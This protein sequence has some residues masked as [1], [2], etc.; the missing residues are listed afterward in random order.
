[1]VGGAPVTII[2]GAVDDN[3]AEETTGMAM[4]ILKAD[5]LLLPSKQASF[6]NSAEVELKVGS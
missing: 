2:L 1:M 6:I 4:L 5:W 3:A